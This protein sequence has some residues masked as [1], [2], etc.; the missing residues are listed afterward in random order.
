M[1]LIHFF[2]IPLLGTLV[3]TLFCSVS[4]F[5][6]NSLQPW[7]IVCQAPL[8]MG[9]SRQEYWSGLPCTPPGYNHIIL[10]Q[11]FNKLY[12]IHIQKKLAEMNQKTLRDKTVKL[13]MTSSKH[14]H[15]SMY[16]FNCFLV[17][18]LSFFLTTIKTLPSG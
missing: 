12:F 6:S 18:C 16:F 15:T 7:T 17:S 1:S 3:I 8:S 11:Y 2:F 4:S 9:F 13:S 10:T 14:T 5:G